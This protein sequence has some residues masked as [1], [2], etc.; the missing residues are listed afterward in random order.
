MKWTRVS[1]LVVTFGLIGAGTVW[2]GCG[3]DDDATTNPVTG[4]DSGTAQDT[5][6]G[7]GDSGGMTD[8]GNMNLDAGTDTGT[9]SGPIDIDAS[10]LNCP[11]YCTNIMS[12]CTGANQQFLNDATCLAMCASIGND[13]GPGQTSGGSLSCHVNHLALAAA[14]P[15]N[16]AIHC[17]HAGPYGYG[18]CGTICDDFCKEYFATGSPCKTEP[19]ATGYTNIDACKTYCNGAA[20][21]DASAGAPGVAQTTPAMLCR[22]YHLENAYNA[23]GTGGGH[24]AHAGAAGGGVCP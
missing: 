21:G 23:G 10:A 12:V 5:S 14:S 20:G 11:Y 22:E 24:C 19:A 15:A 9:D 7:G 8:S 18:T 3:G 2:T 17:P 4:T 16:A 6:T 13:A 1:G